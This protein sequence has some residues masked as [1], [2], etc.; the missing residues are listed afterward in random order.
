MKMII[1]GFKYLLKKLAFS[2]VISLFGIASG[3][4][5]DLCADGSDFSCHNPNAVQLSVSYRQI[6][7]PSD[8]KVVMTYHPPASSSWHN[9][10]L[11]DPSYCLSKTTYL[12]TSYDQGDLSRDTSSYEAGDSKFYCVKGLVAGIGSKESTSPFNIDSYGYPVQDNLQNPID[13]GANAYLFRYATNL[14]YNYLMGTDNG[15]ESIPLFYMNSLFYKNADKGYIPVRW[16]PGQKGLQ[17]TQ[18]ISSQGQTD[19]NLGYFQVSVEGKGGGTNIIVGRINLSDD[20]NLY[21][22]N[23]YDGNIAVSGFKVSADNNSTSN[24]SL[25]ASTSTGADNS[26]NLSLN[27]ILAC[28]NPTADQMEPCNTPGASPSE[29]AIQ[30]DPKNLPVPKP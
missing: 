24:L 22:L 7:L 8:Y 6:N 10:G 18:T 11:W 3:F 17:Y 12:S 2:S 4:C 16:V 25:L 27:I 1:D 13:N 21:Y 23:S 14:Q 5:V 30:C 9:D 26:Q 29:C 28:T 15:V 20:G 19:G